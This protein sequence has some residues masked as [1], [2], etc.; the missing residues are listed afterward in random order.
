M[1]ILFSGQLSEADSN[2]SRFENGNEIREISESE[3]PSSSGEGGPPSIVIV[4]VGVVVECLQLFLLLL[5]KMLRLFG[6]IIRLFVS[7]FVVVSVSRL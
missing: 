7:F 2:M 3:D 1:N 4:Q 6:D 5:L